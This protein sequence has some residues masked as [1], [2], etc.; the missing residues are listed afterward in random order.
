MEAGIPDNDRNLDHLKSHLVSLDPSRLAGTTRL[1]RNKVEAAQVRH[2]ELRQQLD[3]LER[4]LKAADNRHLQHHF[5]QHIEVLLPQ[6]R[7]AFDTIRP[8]TYQGAWKL[9]ANGQ[10]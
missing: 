4:D 6:I 1:M 3:A 8:Y 5:K 9:P 2:A 10:L 7:H